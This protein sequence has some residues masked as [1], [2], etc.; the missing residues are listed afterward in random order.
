MPPIKLAPSKRLHGGAGDGFSVVDV[1]GTGVVV[2]GAG[3][4]VTGAGVVVTGTGVVVL[5]F[6][7]N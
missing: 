5:D 3:V 2:T 1:A 7:K 6:W 4:V